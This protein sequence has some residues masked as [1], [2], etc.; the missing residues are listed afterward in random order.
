M[1]VHHH[2][3]RTSWSGVAA[4]IAYGLGMGLVLMVLTLAIALARQGLV[5]DLR[6]RTALR[7]PRIAAALLVVAGVYVTYYGWYELRVRN[8]DTS[9]GAWPQFV[10]DLN[11]DITEWITSSGPARS[12]W[13]SP[14]S[15]PW[16]LL[17]LAVG[18]VAT[19]R[20]HRRAGGT[21]AD[22]SDRPRHREGPRRQADNLRTPV[23]TQEQTMDLRIFV[24]P[25]QGAT[26][27]EQLAVAQTAEALGFD[28]FFRSDHYLR[29]GDGSG[30]PGPDRH[31]GHPRRHRPRDQHASGSARWSCSATF[32]LPGPLAVAVA[33]VDEM[34]GGRVELGLGAGWY[35]DEHTA[36]GI[37]FPPLGERFDRLEEQLE[38]ITGLWRTPG[39]TRS[40]PSRASTTPGR[41]PG[42][43]QAGAA[44]RP[45]GHHRRRTAHAH[46]PP[47]RP[48]RHRVQRAVRRRSTRSP[49]QRARVR[50]PA[51]P[52]AA[53]PTT[54][55]CSAALVRVLRRDRRGARACG[56]APSAGRSTS[57]ARTARPARRPRCSTRIAAYA[58][59]GA[60]RVYLQVLDLDD[61]EHVDLL[62][63]QVRELL[64]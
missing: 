18:G 56:P 45:A 55:S 14:S 13:C 25:Q 15:S 29:M 43:A 4:F 37:P 52:S 46:A 16:R 49:H 35:D 31:V 30:L 39:A 63:D 10:F 7:E 47:R 58:E 34:S 60:Q 57:C 40:S 27:D 5:A 24:E 51:R 42:A 20:P 17:V 33:Q 3:R 6:R 1:V 61:L 28:G 19:A 64:P 54:S 50:P 9:G 26:Y 62:G 2:R 32:R 36:Y 22:R 12:A 53:T 38:I 41:L 11:G 59:A 8:G 21:A 48:L 23:A 44:R